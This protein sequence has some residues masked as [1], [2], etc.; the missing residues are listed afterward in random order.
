MKEHT[1]SRDVYIGVLGARLSSAH[2]TSEVNFISI[3]NVMMYQM[4]IS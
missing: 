4:Y 3:L 2:R 1:S